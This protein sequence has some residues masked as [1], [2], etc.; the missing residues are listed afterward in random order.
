MRPARDAVAGT[1]LA[2]REDGAQ[3]AVAPKPARGADLDDLGLDATAVG[4][5]VALL[6]IVPAAVVADEVAVD[7][8][9]RHPV[10]VLLAS[11][12]A[13]LGEV[14]RHPPRV[15]ELDPLGVVH[16]GARGAVLAVLLGV[17]I[18]SYSR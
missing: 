17:S 5:L 4:A 16:P 13:V 6:R 9:G 8:L 7:P 1:D 12:G 3:A 18:H 15:G 10:L 11:G 14:H 2:D